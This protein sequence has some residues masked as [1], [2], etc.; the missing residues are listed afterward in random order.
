MENNS[1]WMIEDIIS[2]VNKKEWSEAWELVQAVDIVLH[3]SVLKEVRR[4]EG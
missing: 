2:T 3:R 4:F 1:N